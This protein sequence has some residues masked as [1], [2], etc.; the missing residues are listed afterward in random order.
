MARDCRS[1]GGLGLWLA[2]AAREHRDIEGLFSAFCRELISHDLPVYRGSMGLELLHPEVS[3]SLFVWVDETVKVRETERAQIAQSPS[4]LHS[5][6]RIVDDT[7]RPFRRRLIESVADM[8]LLEELRREGATDYYMVPLPFLDRSRSAVMAFATRHPFGFEDRQIEQLSAA[9]ALFSPYAERHVLRRIAVDLLDTY[10]G[11]RTGQR[12][13]DGRIEPG[14]IERIEATIWMADLRGFTRFSEDA[15]TG[16]LIDALNAWFAVMVEVIEA[17]GGEV[18]K[19]IGD[20]V[21]AI[22]PA[23]GR[24]GNGACED[25]IAAAESFRQRTGALN[26]ERQRQGRRALDFAVALHI[27][28]VAYGN[29]GAPHRMDF[30]VIGPAVNRVSRLQDLAKDL[31]RRIVVSA[32][33]ADCVQCPLVDLGEFPLRGVSGLQRVY[34]VATDR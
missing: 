7:D 18:L 6:T 34:G 16:D 31:G 13:F 5:P 29:V 23:E 33:V 17:H 19:F 25:A 3:G 30:T 21:L 15:T 11:P 32:D 26:K 1:V 2:E 4:Y 12:I 28:E 22:F 20:A 9:A 14:Q 24:G 27:G 10:V 8:P